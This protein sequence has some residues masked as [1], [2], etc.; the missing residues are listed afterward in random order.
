LT[1]TLLSKIKKQKFLFSNIGT[2]GLSAVGITSG[3]A[4]AGSII[5]GGMVA[6][7]FTLAAL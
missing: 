1:N 7:I 5:G 2:A 3:L 4:T 6:G